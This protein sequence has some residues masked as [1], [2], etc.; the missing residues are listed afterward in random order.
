[1]Y[2]KYLAVLLSLVFMLVLSG[3]NNVPDQVFNTR[4]EAEN[5]ASANPDMRSKTFFIQPDGSK[6]SLSSWT[7]QQWQADR[8][9]EVAA[10]Q[11]KLDKLQGTTKETPAETSLYDDQGNQ[12][13]I[14]L[15]QNSNPLMVLNNGALTMVTFDKP[16]HI[17]ELTTYHWNDGQGKS[18]VGTMEIIDQTGKSLGLW[19]GKG[20]DGQGRVVNANWIFSP[21]ISLPA[22]SYT[23]KDSDPATWAQ[24]AGTNGAGMCW[25]RGYFE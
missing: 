2:K 21:N 13:V 24:N 11:A 9:A 8:K 7:S 3:C 10:N 5:Y 14:E 19:S 18:P 22:G 17:T 20:S 23:I 15:F 16:V 25:V 4:S 6:I 12:T 1:M